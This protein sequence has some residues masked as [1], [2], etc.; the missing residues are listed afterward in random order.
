MSPAVTLRSS[1]VTKTR[2][3]SDRAHTVSCARLPQ[4]MAA[5]TD[6]SFSTCR[7]SPSSA[8][9]NA[10]GTDGSLMRLLSDPA[11]HL[12]R[13]RRDQR[14]APLLVVDSADE[15]DEDVRT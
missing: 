11:P 12:A 8:A 4:R 15:N 14:G 3:M 13:N 10:W 5:S 9:A 7:M 6:E 1:M 2:S